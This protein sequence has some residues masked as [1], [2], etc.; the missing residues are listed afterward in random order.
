MLFQFSLF[1]NYNNGFITDFDES[2]LSFV[3]TV[4]CGL[5]SCCMNIKNSCNISM[6]SAEKLLKGEMTN[7]KSK[8]KVLQLDRSTYNHFQ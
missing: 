6:R 7:T 2:D 1:K 5:W 8:I 3:V 4:M